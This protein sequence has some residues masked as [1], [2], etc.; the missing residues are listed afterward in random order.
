MLDKEIRSGKLKKKLEKRKGF[1]YRSIKYYERR[2][3]NEQ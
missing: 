2:N 3:P 1:L